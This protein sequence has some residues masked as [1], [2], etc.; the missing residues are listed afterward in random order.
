MLLIGIT[1]AADDTVCGTLLLDLD[2]R[3][4]TRTVSL[5][6]PLGDDAVERPA[7]AVE[8]FEGGVAVGRRGRQEKA[9]NA[10]CGKEALESLA[11]LA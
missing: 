2:H 7:A 5:V 11:A 8:P 10:L 1:E 9:A 4:L 6:E 3:P